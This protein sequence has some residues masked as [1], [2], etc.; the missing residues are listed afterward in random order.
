MQGTGMAK[1]IAVINDGTEG[2]DYT[3]GCG[4]KV[5]DIEAKDKDAAF[6]KLLEDSHFSEIASG[7]S[8]PDSIEDYS[9]RL[10]EIAEDD[11]KIFS[12]WRSSMTS[13]AARIKKEN[14]EKADLEQ[15]EKLKK[16]LGK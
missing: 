2:C 15:F 7:D 6:A 9:V 5:I 8:E 1:F 12:K 14:D 16:K 13:K 4:T 10:I 3:I 11:K